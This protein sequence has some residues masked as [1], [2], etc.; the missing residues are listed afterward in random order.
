MKN[1]IIT[2]LTAI[3]MF[4]VFDYL[5]PLKLLIVF[6]H[7]SSHAIVAWLTGGEII[8]FVINI[9]QSGYVISSGGNRFLS[10]SSGYIGSLIWGLVIFYAAVKSKHDN[11]ILGV[12]ATIIISIAFIF[13]NDAITIGFSLSVG[14]V[15]FLVAKYASNNMCD[16][17]LRVIGL[18]SMLYVPYDIWTDTILH[19][20]SK[21][22]A[23]MLAEEVGG[24]AVMWGMVW[25]T[26]SFT[27]IGYL[28][29]SLLKNDTD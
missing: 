26:T 11:H 22:D 1:V 3:V 2:V 27:L 21:S 14:V 15:M 23:F 10:L 13:S 12:I 24:T 28:V 16:M 4:F 9:N 18:T 17:V 6:F 29:I 19:S 5:L 25:I 8:E 20:E 7:E